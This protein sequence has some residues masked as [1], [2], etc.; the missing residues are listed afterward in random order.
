MLKP[1]LNQ[2]LYF[3]DYV[4]ESSMLNIIML[5]SVLLQVIVAGS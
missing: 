4:D 2:L 5:I 3:D 1:H